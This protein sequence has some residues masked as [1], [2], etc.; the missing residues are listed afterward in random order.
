MDNFKLIND[1][2]G[3]DYGDGVIA[4]MGSFLREDFG[5]RFLLGRIGGDEFAL[6]GSGQGTREE[7]IDS[8]RRELDA[9]F[10]VFDEAFAAEKASVP[11]SLSIGIDVES[12][13]V[14]FPDMYHR[15]DSALYASKHGGKNGYTFYHSADTGETEEDI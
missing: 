8:I 4:R 12:G 13:E 1:T 3:H 7:V 14:L 11:I 10:A 15:S 2:F 5:E 9:A 6:Y